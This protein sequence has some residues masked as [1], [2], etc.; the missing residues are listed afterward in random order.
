M[1]KVGAYGQLL[2]V[3]KRGLYGVHVF[4]DRVRV[5]L[6]RTLGG[7]G[8]RLF[9]RNH[10]QAKDRWSLFV[11]VRVRAMVQAGRTLY[12]AG[13]PDIVPPK[14]PLAAIEG[15]R[16]AA[17]WAVSTA[18]GEKLSELKLDAVPVFDGMIAANGRL[19]VCTQNGRVTC[20]GG[21]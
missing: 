17:L 14:D 16:G 18:N 8:Q 19:I 13:P 15:R 12:I 21:R 3:D 1:R 20:L 9:A 11:P 7:K 4:V 10:G 5:R 2:V 6:G